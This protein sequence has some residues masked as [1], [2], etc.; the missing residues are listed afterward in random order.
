MSTLSLLEHPAFNDQKTGRVHDV[1]STRVVAFIVARLEGTAPVGHPILVC[2]VKT[3]DAR[4]EFG[5]VVGFSDDGEMF[6]LVL[7][8]DRRLSG[9]PGLGV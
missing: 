6:V 9:K 2:G 1:V 7:P 8:A 4:V 3:T 5:R